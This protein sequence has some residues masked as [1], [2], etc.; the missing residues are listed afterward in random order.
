LNTKAADI[1]RWENVRVLNLRQT[2]NSNS[3]T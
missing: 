1:Q 3:F 2:F